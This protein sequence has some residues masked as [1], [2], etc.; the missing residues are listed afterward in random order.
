[1]R[2]QRPLHARWAA[3]SLRRLRVGRVR[4]A[5]SS[6][7]ASRLWRALQE[8]RV[9]PA[10]P[11]SRAARVRLTLRLPP[12]ARVRRA[13][14]AL[15]AGRVCRALPSLRAAL[16]RLVLRAGRVR[17]QLLSHL[18]VRAGRTRLVRRGP[19]VFRTRSVLLGLLAW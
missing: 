3:S 5:L 12:A 16:V 9:R 15:W 14:P 2:L 17:L 11:L 1:M 6:L 10:L 13:L 8:R 7:L 19:L 4:L 18:A